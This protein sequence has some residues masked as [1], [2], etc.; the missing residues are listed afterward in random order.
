MPVN[1]ELYQKLQ[2]V[3]K[4][5]QVPVFISGNQSEINQFLNKVYRKPMYDTGS[6][7]RTNL[8][9]EQ[10]KQA[11]NYDIKIFGGG[12]GVILN[13]SVRVLNCV[14]PVHEGTQLDQPYK[15]KGVIVGIL[16]TGLDYRHPDFY[17]EN[18]HTRIHS[19][20]DH[21]MSGN[22]PAPYNYG[23]ECDSLSI[24]NQTCPSMDQNWAEFGSAHGTHVTG[25]AAGFD[26]VDG[27]FS[28]NAPE[29][30]IIGIALDYNNFNTSIIDGT[31]YIYDIAQEKG[32]PA[33]INL[34]SGNYGG[35][36]DGQD[37]FTLM[38]ND[39]ITETPGRAFVMAAGNGGQ[40]FLNTRHFVTSQEQFTYFK[41]VEVGAEDRFSWTV[42]ADDVDLENVNFQVQVDDSST[43][44]KLGET[45]V[46]N[47]IDDIGNPG[48]GTILKTIELFDSTGL[49]LGILNIFV[50]KN[51]NVYSLLF[52]AREVDTSHYWRF[53]TS[54][55]GLLDIYSGVL[56]GRSPFVRDTELPTSFPEIN[57]YTTPTEDQSI[58]GFYGASE[59]V[60]TVGNYIS[61]NSWTRYDGTPSVSTT[62]GE[63]GSISP[64][65]SRGP[66]RDG[67]IKPEITSTG[68]FVTSA[69]NLDFINFHIANGS[70]FGRIHPDGMHFRQAGT[71]M[72]AP[73]VAGGIA[74]LLQRSPDLTNAEIRELVFNNATRDEFTGPDVNNTSGYG[75]FCAY[76]ILVADGAK[77]T[78]DM[79]TTISILPTTGI[80]GPRIMRTIVEVRE[81]SGVPT[82]PDDDIIL[83][84]TTDPNYTFEWEENASVIGG[85]SGLENNLWEYDATLAGN[86]LWIFRR[87]KDSNGLTVPLD[88]LESS[89]FGFIGTYDAGSSG[90]NSTITITILNNS[91]GEENSNNNTDNATIN[92]IP[93]TQ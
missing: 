81:V 17:D 11:S 32:M 30:T 91:G 25:I 31:K 86:G 53:N 44:E 73:A 48:N 43:F 70:R 26:Q 7:T 27:T 83:T 54:G 12:K 69:S 35:A 2:E 61:K 16:D 36:H 82:N 64:G 77:L 90:G 65:S 92:Y 41:D 23:Y 24:A 42:Y 59:E 71:S 47:I 76:D 28:G 29:A 62:I 67:R 39:L 46:L 75:K 68:T 15:G 9:L 84:I 49:S 20:W 6:G 21:R 37:V 22:A 5:E 52:D 1:I 79:N 33:V 14:T 4:T 93:A 57:S 78:A 56:I 55:S 3:D 19:I 58:V 74:L 87:I 66:T 18:G 40:G 63:V 85:E 8:S 50:E 80:Q 60:I 10:I 13:D 88:A 89:S 34:S 45:E 51:N 38:L 72:S